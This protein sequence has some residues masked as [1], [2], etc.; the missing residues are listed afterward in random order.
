MLLRAGYPTLNP[1]GRGEGIISPPIKTSGRCLLT[2]CPY[3][4]PL[5]YLIYSSHLPI[6]PLTFKVNNTKIFTKHVK[7]IYWTKQ[8]CFL[9]N[10]FVLWNFLTKFKLPLNDNSFQVPKL[11]S[12]YFVAQ[13][14]I[15]LRCHPNG[16]CTWKP[17]SWVMNTMLYIAVLIMET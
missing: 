17:G 14:L 6:Y 9:N 10:V 4:M 1:S 12:Y 3:K 7:H 11:F 15:S 2:T 13:R 5:N 8:C 16:K